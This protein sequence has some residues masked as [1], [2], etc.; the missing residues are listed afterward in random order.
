MPLALAL[1]LRTS[2][3]EPMQISPHNRS[4]GERLEYRALER[5]SHR[6]YRCLFSDLDLASHLREYI[7]NLA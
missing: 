7:L 3:Y 1:G 4:Q 5:Y 2:R 6:F